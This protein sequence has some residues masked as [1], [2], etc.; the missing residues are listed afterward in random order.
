MVGKIEITTMFC[1]VVF[2]GGFFG[3]MFVFLAWLL[4]VLNI[5]LLNC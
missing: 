4:G 1:I 3:F 5:F 2:F